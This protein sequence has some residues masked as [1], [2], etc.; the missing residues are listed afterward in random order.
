VRSALLRFAIASLLALLA[1][2]AVTVLVGRSLAETTALDEA[3]SRTAAFAGFVAPLVDSATRAGDPESIAALND[4][5]RSRM[6]DGSI[7]HIKLWASDS[8]IIWSD[9]PAL[10]GTT[11]ELEPDEAAL[12]GTENVVSDL[13]DLSKPENTLEADESPLVEVYAGTFDLDGEP[14]LVEMYWPGEQIQAVQTAIVTRSA[15]LA[16]GALFLF[17]LVILGLALSLA[18][19]VARGQVDRHN[20]LRDALAASELERGR[21]AQDLHDGVIQDLAGLSY[22]VPSV[23]GQL[24]PEM[25]SLRRVLDQVGLVLRQDVAALRTLLTDIYPADLA[26]G[27]LETEV[28]VLARRAAD[29]DVDVEVDI[30]EGMSD[31]SL[32]VSRLVYRVVREGLRNVVKHAEATH[33]WVAARRVGPDVVVTVLDDGQGLVPDLDTEGH[34]GLRLLEQTVRDVGGRLT[35][36]NRPGGGVALTASFPLTFGADA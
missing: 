36:E 1:V 13:S 24:P 2:G 8:T 17:L 27:G 31:I 25:G 34:V 3:R 32:E 5:M 35:V 15:P 4:V 22:A 21:L 6:G 29:S 20:L 16:L 9:E 18:R 28:G 19:R 26:S 23:A 14:L 30:A 12:F 10:I 11:F 33:A 7:A